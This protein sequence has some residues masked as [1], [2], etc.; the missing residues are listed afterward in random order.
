MTN[1]TIS[2][3]FN[4]ISSLLTSIPLILISNSDI[5]VISVPPG[6]T[7][8][9]SFVVAKLLKKKIIIDYRDEW[10][11]H[12]IGYVKSNYSKK[13]YIL[14]K[15]LMSNCYKKSNSIITVT[16]PLIRSLSSRGVKNIKFIP[17]GADCKYFKPYYKYQERDEFKKSYGFN[18][19][20]FI[21]VYSGGIGGYYRI[22]IVI[23]ALK[24]V[25]DRIPNIK[26]LVIGY[27]LTSQIDDL[28]TLSKKLNLD[29]NV[30]FISAKADELSKLLSCCNVGVVP[31]DSNPLWKNSLPVKS[32][33]YL[34][35]G[36]PLIST[37]YKDS[38]LGKM[39]EENEIG[40]IS[41]PEDIDALAKA[42]EKIY[43]SNL[44]ISSKRAI[45][46][47]RK[48]YDRNDTA[49]EFMELLETVAKS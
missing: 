32:F 23:E 13:A 5:V 16:S 21:L 37:V 6:E 10:E 40:V 24:K 34:A 4:I 31:Y 45:S 28:M 19:E 41:N 1:N 48:N 49:K 43:Y 12:L 27:G 42:I 38:V 36:L 22:D 29:N 26:L 30:L 25:V 17:N 14:L 20:D 15:S 7:A 47:V 18:K 3:I 33:E 46:F 35:C 9:G 2:L 44:S 8:F 39:I 11:D